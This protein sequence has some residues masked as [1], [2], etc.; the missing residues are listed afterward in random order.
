[1]MHAP[2]YLIGRCNISEGAYCDIVV[3]DPN[4]FQNRHG[5]NGENFM[6]NVITFENQVGRNF[7]QD[8]FLGLSEHTWEK[9]NFFNNAVF[10]LFA[11]FK[12]LHLL[13]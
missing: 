3:R 12:A 7:L 5:Y 13:I 10:D 11:F 1:M 2:Q 8:Y 4:V 9:R 6:V